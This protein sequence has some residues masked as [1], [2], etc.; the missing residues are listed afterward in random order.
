MRAHKTTDEA[1]LVSGELGEDAFEE[2]SVDE[3]AW[4]LTE[5]EGNVVVVSAS[6]G[7][8]AVWRGQEPGTWW[9][10]D[11]PMDDPNDATPF[12]GVAREALEKAVEMAG[13]V[14]AR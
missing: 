1:N 5:K 4:H 2:C 3:L 13:F 14:E 12:E 7:Q 6:V 9:L 8:T 11:V 10:Q